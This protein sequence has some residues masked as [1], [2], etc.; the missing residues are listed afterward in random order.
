MHA[1]LL[2][3]IK[4]TREQSGEKRYTQEKE[5]PD[6]YVCLCLHVCKCLAL[7][8][9]IMFF[10]YYNVKD[11]A[12]KAVYS[13]HRI[14]RCVRQDLN[15]R[16]CVYCFVSSLRNQH[17]TVCKCEKIFNMNNHR[18]EKNSTQLRSLNTRPTNTIVTLRCERYISKIQCQR[19]D[20]MAVCSLK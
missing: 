1:Q 14:T 15:S 17:K 4:E 2:V 8:S 9:L 13:L 5:T 16:V 6:V 19:G 10:C 18:R 20:I 7:L 3:K 11:S 12:G